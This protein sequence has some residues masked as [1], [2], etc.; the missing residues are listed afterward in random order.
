MAD[1]VG[2]LLKQNTD[3]AEFHRAVRRA[4]LA[5]SLGQIFEVY[6]FLIF[7]F[8]AAHIGRAFF[9]S[10]DPTLSLLHSLATFGVGF[11]MRPLGAIV[12]GYF[13]DRIGR[14]KTLALTIG[15]M[16]IATGMTGLVP[17]YQAIGIAGPILLV[18]CRMLQGFSM[19]AEWG[20]AAT[21]LA[22][23]APPAQR[24][25]LSSFQSASGGIA[26]LLAIFTTAALGNWL[27]STALDSWGWR[28]PFLF[29]CL[30][31][32]VAL[33]MRNRVT[34]TPVF[35]NLALTKAHTRVP[36][37]EAFQSHGRQMIVAMA[38]IALIITLQYMFV[39]FLPAY[40]T[41]T[42]KIDHRAALYTTGVGVVIYVV[43]T[44]VVGGFSDRIGRKGP[45]L[46]CAASSLALAY[47]VFGLLT[48]YPTATSLLVAQILANVIQPLATG[49][50]TAT[51]A[52][53]F[54]TSVRF[55]ALSVSYAIGTT[56]FGGF[57]PFVATY[58]VEVTGNP[59]APAYYLM[60]AALISGVAVYFVRIPEAQSRLS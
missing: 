3:T 56:I 37:R 31:G 38:L 46:L 40:A 52:E 29:G 18:S 48:S 44:P 34:E 51:L 30:L 11:L 9:P 27:D 14:R 24:G 4:V 23:H 49:V 36:L 43:L 42:L 22:E 53:M 6:D 47:P 45:L 5:G 16:A 19:G 25:L 58:L 32:P 50:I 1:A 12:M 7:G 15:L 35:A 20:G 41:D 55:T 28:L 60:A 33:Y 13:G 26:S 8:F 54:P 39:I 10:T 57:A 59:V 2:A 21:F 17:S